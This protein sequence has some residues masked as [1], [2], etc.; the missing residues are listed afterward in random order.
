MKTL[1]DGWYIVINACK[2]LSLRFGE[3]FLHYH[4]IAC[5]QYPYSHDYRVYRLYDKNL[6]VEEE[7]GRLLKGLLGYF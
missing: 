7:A 6:G 5:L 2:L 1:K 3:I 4:N